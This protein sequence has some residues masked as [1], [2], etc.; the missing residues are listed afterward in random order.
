MPLPSAG[1]H[2]SVVATGFPFSVTVAVTLMT[3]GFFPSIEKIFCA[4]RP[5]SSA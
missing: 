3:Y 5:D 1:P 4:R 2:R